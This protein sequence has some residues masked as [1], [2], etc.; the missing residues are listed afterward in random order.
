MLGA[1]GDEEGGIVED[2]RRDGADRASDVPL[3]ID[4]AVVQHRVGFAPHETV[5]GGLAF[6]GDGA[7]PDGV[8]RRK[9]SRRHE[10]QVTKHARDPR[11]IESVR[12]GRMSDGERSGS[13]V[14][15]LPTT[16]TSYT[17]T[18]TPAEQLATEENALKSL[19]SAASDARSAAISPS[20][21]PPPSAEAARPSPISL[22]GMG[23]K[24]ARWLAG[25]PLARMRAP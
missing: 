10:T 25:Y 1:A 22:P 12:Q 23:A 4:V 24:P 13:L 8:A 17:R 20:A 3:L 18:S 19:S 11:D 6:D 14:A 16:T 2:A 7:K 15:L 9:L 21:L 5:S